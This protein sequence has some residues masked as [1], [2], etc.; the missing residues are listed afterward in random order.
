MG[1]SNFVYLEDVQVVAVTDKAVLIVH[2]DVS[3][4]IPLTQ[5]APDD[6]A[7]LKRGEG[8]TIGITEWIANEKGIEV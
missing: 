4:W 2:D 1:N 6:V 8:F 3:N 5:V 7:G